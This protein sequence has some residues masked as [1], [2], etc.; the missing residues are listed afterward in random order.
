M[1]SRSLWCIRIAIFL[2]Q[3]GSGAGDLV[4]RSGPEVGPSF[5]LRVI[6]VLGKLE[7]EDIFLEV[8]EPERIPGIASCRKA[9][10]GRPG[11]LR[12]IDL[13]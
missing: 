10:L 7:A 5:D 6:A 8:D 12:I 3:C 9:S 4:R 11:S 2:P 13:N 1:K